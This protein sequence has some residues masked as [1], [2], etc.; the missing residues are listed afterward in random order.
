MGM[1]LSI[2]IAVKAHMSKTKTIFLNERFH[3]LC[4]PIFN[5]TSYYTY[6]ENNKILIFFF[7]YLLEQT[8]KRTHSYTKPTVMLIS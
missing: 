2:Q 1:Y 7:V 4:L 5:K 6:N 8:Q 3:N